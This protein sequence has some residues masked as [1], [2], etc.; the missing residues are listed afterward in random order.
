M[1]L[2]NDIFDIKRPQRDPQSGDLLV[3][4]PFLSEVH[5]RRA[6]ILLVD[7]N[8]TEGTV[9]LVLNHRSNLSLNSVLRNASCPSNIPLH[10]GGP[11]EH[12]RL[13]YL[14]TLGNRFR[15]S[16]QLENGLYIG[17]NFNDVLEYLNSEEYDEQCI[18]FFAGYSGWTAGQL[19]KEI[20]EKTWVVTSLANTGAAM[21]AHDDTYWQEIVKSLGEEYR[22]WLLCPQKPHFN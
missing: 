14:H 16:V 2:I 13:L 9:G 12:G 22:S 7:H 18:K 8:D 5:F 11:V 10:I 3:V 19:K 6:V 15:E 21:T 4:E 20:E 17:G 1:K